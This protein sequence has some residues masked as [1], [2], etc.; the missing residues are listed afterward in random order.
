AR[1]RA[2]GGGAAVPRPPQPDAD[3]LLLGESREEASEPLLDRRD[4]LPSRSGCCCGAGKPRPRRSRPRSSIHGLSSSSVSSFSSVPSRPARRSRRISRS[5]TCEEMARESWSK[6]GCCC[7]SA[8][9][10][11]AGDSM[12]S[13]LRPAQSSAFC[14]NS[15]S[16]ASRLCSVLVALILDRR[17]VVAVTVSRSV[18]AGK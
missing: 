12:R 10:G 1:P 16:R 6:H 3:T 2:T 14:T 8:E 13:D 4:S 11:D 15:C 5:V 17:S 18:E 9:L 7:P